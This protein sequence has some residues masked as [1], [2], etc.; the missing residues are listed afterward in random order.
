MGERTN[1]LGVVPII[2]GATA[3]INRDRARLLAVGERLQEVGQPGVPAMLSDEPL[4][5]CNARVAR[6]AR[7]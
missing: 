5:V 7:R 4:H 3:V 6:T 2:A 1:N